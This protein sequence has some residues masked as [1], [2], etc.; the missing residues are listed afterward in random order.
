VGGD[1]AD[2]E[3]GESSYDKTPLRPLLTLA[4]AGAALL[5][6]LREIRCPVLIMTSPNDHVVNPADSDVLAAAVSGPVERVTLERSYHVAPIDYD[7]DVVQER[8][9]EFVRRVTS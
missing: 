6:R 7:R 8:A 1:V 2:P 5:A 3:V 9:V 4:D